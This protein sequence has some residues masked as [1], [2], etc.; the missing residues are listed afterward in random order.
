MTQIGT[1]EWRAPEI[2]QRV[3]DVLTESQEEL[4]LKAVYYGFQQLIPEYPA[5]SVESGRKRRTLEG[6]HRFGVSFSV[7]MV[8][9]HGAIRSTTVTKKESE[10]LAQ[11]VED[12]LHEDFYLGGLVLFGYIASIE[13]GIRA[14]GEDMIRATRLAWEG[15]SREGF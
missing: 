10:E 2:T 4:G 12:K 14:R 9:E 7:L 15:L 6:T 8:L 11:L 5:I 13:P 3:V 1:L